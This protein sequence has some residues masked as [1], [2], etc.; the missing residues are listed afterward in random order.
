MTWKAAAQVEPLNMPTGVKFVLVK[1][2]NHADNDGYD[3]WPSYQRVA[4]FTGQAF[5]T[6]QRA[7]E[8]M[9]DE[10][11]LIA[12][13]DPYGGR[14]KR[15][16]GI[17]YRIDFERARELYGFWIERRTNAGFVFELV[18]ALVVVENGITDDA[19][20]GDVVVG[21]TVDTESTVSETETVD[22]DAE[23]VDIDGVN[24][25]HESPATPQET[26]VSRAESSK[27]P[28]ESARAREAGG[29]DPEGPPPACAIW[30][31][32][33][34][35]LE[36]LDCWPLLERAIPAEDDGEI[37]TLAV[38]APAVGFAILAW[39]ARDAERALYKDGK[40][41]RIACRVKRWVQPALIQRGVGGGVP[42]AAA[43]RREG[44]LVTLEDPAWQMW[45]SKVGELEQHDC[46]V[47]IAECLPDD[48]YGGELVLF[49]GS[50]G[51]ANMMSEDLGDRVSR[52]IGLP[53]RPRFLWCLDVLQKARS[54][55]RG[56][57]AMAVG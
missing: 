10:G 48:I 29:D 52:V 47:A 5:K 38:E 37:L 54:T 51:V 23:T 13:G 30:R 49:C 32:N 9:R 2:A 41:R 20:P 25:G 19:E 39:A 12:Q 22:S 17:A 1:Y 15:G 35:R 21:E 16:R 14:G 8:R 3:T 40:G 7:V 56:R 11:I 31:D 53:V 43:N 27:N 57:S 46:Q 55:A 42:D 36:A 34:A 50:S 18:P 44:D 4:H 33:R 26:A 45:T 6:V 24:C 28:P